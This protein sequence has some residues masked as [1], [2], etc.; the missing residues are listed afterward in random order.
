MPM[1]WLQATKPVLEAPPGVREE[2]WI[3]EQI[4]QRM[5]L[6]AA[7]GQLRLRLL[8]KCGIRITP[9]FMMDALLRTSKVGDWFGLRRGGLSIKKREAQP[10][11]VALRADAVY[12]RASEL[13]V[14]SDGKV[15]LGERPV[16]DALRDLR[17]PSTGLVL[18]GRRELTSIN[19]WMHNVGSNKSPA[20]FVNPVDAQEN[21]L[22]T[23]DEVALTTKTGTVTVP[24][25]V[26]DKIVHGVVSYPHGYGHR[27]GWRAAN[28]LDGV[29][30]N[31]LLSADPSVKDAL[32]GV[33]HL[34]GVPVEMRRMPVSAPSEMARRE[35][36][37]ARAEDDPIA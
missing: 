25:E 24:V 35:G 18:I 7:S 28:D 3:F 21:G 30:I 36:A 37:L 15:R 17:A 20:L 14:H 1:P 29:S 16:L 2:W 23:G 5:G 4:A 6:G 9:R 13:I 22:A 31:A 33:S 34:D 27:G 32:S 26:T 10:H 19:S 11:G 8:T 12:G